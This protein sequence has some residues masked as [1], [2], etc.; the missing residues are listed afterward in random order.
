ML[1]SRIELSTG[2]T[3]RVADASALFTGKGHTG[4][5]TAGA[6]NMPTQLVLDEFHLC[7]LPP[8]AIDLAWRRDPNSFLFS[9]VR[10]VREQGFIDFAF[11][12]LIYVVGM[13]DDTD[14]PML[15]HDQL[16]LFFP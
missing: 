13:H 1:V 3:R 4:S 15:F 10:Q 6:F 9:Q 12:R 2:G 14:Q 7:S 11:P 8:P 5:L 16:D